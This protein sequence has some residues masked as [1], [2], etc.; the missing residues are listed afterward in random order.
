[1]AARLGAARTGGLLGLPWLRQPQDLLAR[2]EHV[3]ARCDALVAEAAAL[4]PSARVLRR[5]DRISEALCSALDV[6]ALLQAVHPEPEWM[7]AADAASMAVGA[8]MARLN[9]D[10][11]LYDAVQR[12]RRAPAVR[13]AL[14]EEEARFAELICAEFE[15][16]GVHLPPAG[17]ARA[18][19]LSG[20]IARL[21][22]DYMG[23]LA[24]GGPR[25]RA[26]RPSGPSD[27]AAV[28]AG[29]GLES[30][31]WVRSELVRA[32]PAHVGALLVRDGDLSLLPDEPAVAAAV[33]KW[34][35]DEPLRRAAHRRAHAAAGRANLG[36]LSALLDARLELA[37]ELGF[38]SHTRSA[39]AYGRMAASEGEVE[40]FLALVEGRIRPRLDAELSE[41]SAAKAARDGGGG[42]PLGAWDVPFYTGMLKAR[43][44]QL[45]PRRLCRYFELERAL[46]GLSGLFSRLF[47]LSLHEQPL[48]PG[49]GWAQG[50]RKFALVETAAGKRSEP[51]GTIYL[52]LFSR[53]RKQPLSATFTLSAGRRAGPGARTDADGDGGEAALP[54][55][56]VAIVCAFPAPTP[57]SASAPSLLSH[58]E[59]TTLYHEAGHALHALLS[60]TSFQHLSGVR[61][62]LD[63][64][65]CPALLLERFACDWRVLRGWATDVHTNEPIPEELVAALAGSASHFAGYDNALQLLYA[66]TDLAF[67]GDTP[68]SADT[69]GA[70]RGL[71]EAAFGPRLPWVEGADWHASFSHLVGYGGGYYAYLWAR[72]LSAQL[73]QERFA[74]DPLSQSAGADVRAALLEPGNARP[75]A[76]LLSDALRG[77]P[78]CTEAFAR[79][80]TGGGQGSEPG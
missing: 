74:E 20:R 4:P 77:Q 53:E 5:V 39:L 15:A 32:L 55:P 23:A 47:R 26:G 37:R 21:S 63:F 18:H 19:E 60:T 3:R 56:T 48:A 58:S 27:L 14:S 64:V 30:P 66:R 45:Q 31:L 17:Q 16:D 12:V 69:S 9:T 65:E 34:C 2:A 57:G 78:L 41:L 68:P 44:W 73:W 7:E 40:A 80:L 49:E 24:A 35:A 25:A 28:A 13:G 72:S 22:A 1:M 38:A 11:R 75:P 33:L 62:P 61:G 8:T 79:E 54:L 10:R 36:T 71:H 43:R 52:D 46:G 6:A 70:V 51:I 29:R 76:A 42:A 59:L 50:V 67:H